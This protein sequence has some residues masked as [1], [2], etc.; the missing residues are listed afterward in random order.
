MLTNQRWWCRGP[1][2][3]E[4]CPLEVDKEDTARIEYGWMKSS[5]WRWVEGFALFSPRHS[6]FVL[7]LHL[8][9]TPTTTIAR[10]AMAAMAAATGMARLLA[11]APSTSAAPRSGA[12]APRPSSSF[13]PRRHHSVLPSSGRRL[14]S[15]HLANARN[16]PAERKSVTVTPPESEMSPA[17]LKA[18]EEA[19]A[20]LEGQQPGFWEGPQWNT[21]GWIIQYMWV[22]GVGVSIIACLIA[23]RTYNFGATD[24]KNT[25]V[26]KEAIEFQT[27]GGAE[28]SGLSAFD[29]SNQ[30]AP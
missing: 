19:S 28:G 3:A 8:Q 10:R 6:V 13:S 15:L 7:P 14:G 23:V 30:E 2:K 11:S 4:N 17:E 12:P 24:F 27:E 21:L 5:P 1:K 20:K 22:F 26:F 29:E 9:C 18:Y 16:V 25:E